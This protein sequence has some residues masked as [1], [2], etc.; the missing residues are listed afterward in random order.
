MKVVKKDLVVVRMEVKNIWKLM[1][2]KRAKMGKGKRKM[3]L[4]VKMDLL[5][6]KYHQMAHAYLIL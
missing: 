3:N 1:N 6:L 5:D 2:R 4:S